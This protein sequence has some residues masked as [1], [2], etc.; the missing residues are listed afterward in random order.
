MP[1]PRSARAGVLA[2]LLAAA[3]LLGAD[4]SRPDPATFK[5]GK[6]SEQ[7]IRD[8]FGEPSAE[9]STQVEGRLVTRLQYAYVEVRSTVIPVR[10]MV[11]SFH[12][13]RLVGFEYLSSFVADETVFDEASVKRIKRGE[14]T[15]AEVLG[16]V[17]TPTGQFIYPSPAVRT[18][19]RHADVYGYSRTDKIASS[20]TLDAIS[21]VLIVTFDDRDVVVETSLVITSTSNEMR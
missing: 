18:P 11:Y 13:G 14:T 10:S 19:G 1:P 17:G 9:N 4:F 8:R 2:V 21:K 16:L 15:R 6:T 7:E 3:C 20:R 12:E 5:L